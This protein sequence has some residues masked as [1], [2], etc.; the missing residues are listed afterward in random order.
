MHPLETNQNIEISTILIKKSSNDGI[1]FR[2]RMRDQ[3]ASVLLLASV[4]STYH[5]VPKGGALYH[6]LAA[7][8]F[9]QS[10]SVVGL[11]LIGVSETTDAP[12]R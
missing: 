8:P 7:L 2:K 4:N 1:Y 11:K 10:Q 6:Y 9:E 12:K 3:F 5:R